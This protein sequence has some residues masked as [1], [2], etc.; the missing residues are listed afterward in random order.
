[1]QSGK[2]I[3]AIGDPM[4]HR[5]WLC[6]VSFTILIKTERLC[7]CMPSIVSKSFAFEIAAGKYAIYIPAGDTGVA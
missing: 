4:A 2:I 5:S 7:E 1:M 6:T 3:E